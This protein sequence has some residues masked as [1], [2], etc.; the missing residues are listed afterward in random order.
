VKEKSPIDDFLRHDRE[1][2]I[3]DHDQRPARTIVTDDR[4]RVFRFDENSVQ[5]QAARDNGEPRDQY[6]PVAKTV[7]SKTIAIESPVAEQ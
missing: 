1:D 6:A 7:Q 4:Q 5:R 3:G 2:G